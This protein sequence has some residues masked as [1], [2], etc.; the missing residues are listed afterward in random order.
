LTDAGISRD[1]SSLGLHKPKILKLIIIRN[2][3]HEDFDSIREL[4]RAAFAE[5]E[6]GHNGEADLVDSIRADS[7]SRLSLVACQEGRVVGHILFSPVIIRTSGEEFSGMGL[8]PMSVDPLHQRKG[9]GSSLISKGL[10]RLFADECAFVVVLGDA[11]YYTRFGFQPAAE[12]S[13]E[14]GFRGIPQDVFFIQTNP[15][16]LLA[17]M[18]R[19]R[20]YYGPSFGAQHDN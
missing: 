6:Y 18:P 9:I 10:S 20:A 5:S 2:E 11:G 8:A 7:S 3:S 4:T 14:H 19:G 1:S 13:V 15:D 12:L 17:S 16:S